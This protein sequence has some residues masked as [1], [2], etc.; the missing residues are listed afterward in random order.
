MQARLGQA[1]VARATLEQWL[2]SY[3]G[4]PDTPDALALLAQVFEAL[5]DLPRAARTWQRLGETYPRYPRAAAALR[6][7]H[8][9]WAQGPSEQRPPLAPERLLAS[10]EA[11]MQAGQ[12]EEVERRLDLLHAAKLPPSLAARVLLARGEAALRR[13]RLALAHTLL[14]QVLR[15]YPHGEHVAAAH[16]WLAVVHRRQGH[17]AHSERQLRRL[18]AAHPRSPWAAQ[19]LLDLATLLAERQHLT[20]AAKLYAQLARDFPTHPEAAESQWQA[21]WLHYRLQRY[22]TAARLWQALRQR[23]PDSPV[24]PRALYW[25]A[26]A[27]QE[28]GKTQAAASLYRQLAE[29][30]P[31]HYYGLQAQARLQELGIPVADP[32]SEALLDGDTPAPPPAPAAD[33]RAAFHL[34]R[35][36][37]LQALQLHALA[38]RE[39]AALQRLLP[40]TPAH[41]FFVAELLAASGHYLPAFRLLNALVADL[42]AAEVRRLPGRFWELLYPRLFWETVQRQAQRTGLDPYL[43]LSVMRQESAFD[44]LA[45]SPA[46]AR[47]LMQL[48]PATARDVARQLRW[49][50]PSRAALHRPE[51]NLA[52]G[53]HY[54][55]S[56]L[57][58]YEGNLVLALAAYHAGPR[59][60]T[61]WQQAWG[62]RPPDE[63]IERLPIEATRLYVKLVLRN[64]AVYARLYTAVSRS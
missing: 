54:L 15:R 8:R 53:T 37:E 5:G 1:A 41:R 58:R 10:L 46:G 59:R 14:H 21:G 25:Q 11:L 28:S 30:Y 52:L 61:A 3:P 12:W 35:V 9:L 56:L 50:R 26:R 51:A 44:P 57:Q 43:V 60:A 42:P 24:L 39:A 36:R 47:G 62:E 17:T 32:L 49:P 20:R 7:S 16:Y 31:V 40:D 22:R 34:Q 29:A 18:I 27:L 2:A 19:A 38:A 64:L 55:A 4:H 63:F 45:V 33:S 48:M 6:R 13:G 23:F